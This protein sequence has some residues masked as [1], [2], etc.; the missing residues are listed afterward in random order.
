MGE[1]QALSRLFPE[2]AGAFTTLG[3][4]LEADQDNDDPGVYAF[5]KTIGRTGIFGLRRVRASTYK[6]QIGTISNPVLGQIEDVQTAAVADRRA[7]A[8]IWAYSSTGFPDLDAA[9]DGKHSIIATVLPLRDFPIDAE[10]GLPDTTQLQSQGGELADLDSGDPDLST[11]PFDTLDGAEAVLPQVA[12]GKPG[13]ETFDLGTTKGGLATSLF[14]QD[15][16]KTVFVSQVLKG[17]IL[18]FCDEDGNDL[19]SS[20][21]FLQVGTD[22][23]TGDPVEIVQG[24]TIFVT[25]PGATNIVA[26]DPPTTE[27]LEKLA[28]NL[29]F[30]R[31]GFD[32]GINGRN[33]TLF[34]KTLRSFSDPSL[35]GFKEW[36]GQR[37]PLPG[38][39]VDMDV[40]FRNSNTEPTE[41]PA[42][43]GSFYNDD[44]D[45]IIPYLSITDTEIERL[46]QAQ[47]VFNVIRYTDTAEPGALYPDEIHGTDGVVYF[48]VTGS[49]PPGALITSRD[50]TPVTTQGF[51]YPRSG[52]GDLRPY[53]LL[54]IQTDPSG[55]TIRVGSQG[56]L[57]VGRI[58]PFNGLETRVEPPRFVSPTTEGD[59]IRYIFE[60][61]IQH[62]AVESPQTGI[63]VSRTGTVTTFDASGAS[64]IFAF[65]NGAGG[66]IG[67]L[68][69]IVSPPGVF[70]YPN[71][72]N[73][74]RINLFKPAT[75]TYLQTVEIRVDT[76]GAG[77]IAIGDLAPAGE[78]INAQPTFASKVFAIDTNNPIVTIAAIPGP[79][80]LPEDPLNP[81]KSLPLW[82]TI[83]VD[84][85]SGAQAASVT[86]SVG[87][88]RLT[89][90]ETLDFRSVLD[91][92]APP[93]DSRNVAGSLDIQF[94]SGPT[95]DAVT[96]NAASETN[97]GAVFYFAARSTAWPYV[98]TFNSVGI[99]GNGKGTVRVT[100]F[101]GFGNSPVVTPPGGGAI[102]AAVPSSG[103]D[104][105]G[106]I[107]DGTGVCE[108]ADVVTVPTGGYYDF[109]NRI[110][111]P[112]VAN[113][114]IDNIESGDILII[115]SSDGT[116]VGTTKAGTYLVKHAIKPTV[117]TSYVEQILTVETRPVSRGW[118]NI[119]FPTLVDADVSG[120]GTITVS[121]I[122]GPGTNGSTFASSGRLYIIRDEKDITDTISIAYT[123]IDVNTGEFTVVSGS[124]LDDDGATPV[125]DSVFDSLS[126][127]LKVSGMVYL[128]VN[129]SNALEFD[130]PMPPNNVLGYRGDG[131]F[132]ATDGGTAYGL[133]G[134]TIRNN[135]L[136]GSLVFDYE[137]D[138]NPL[139]V[140]TQL[141]VADQIRVR[142]YSPVVA[143][144]FQTDEDAVFYPNVPKFIDLS[145]VSAASWDT[146][147]N[148][149]AFGVA[150]IFPGDAFDTENSSNEGAR[151]QAG[152]FLEPSFPRSIF[153][154]DGATPHVVDAARSLTSSDV[155]M[156]S[157][158]D[159]GIL[160]T[161]AP[162]GIF[163]T[164]EGVSF[165]VR[166]I[167]RFHQAQETASD[168][169]RGL[170]FAYE[171]RT[172]TVT[173][174][175]SDTVGSGVWPYVLRATGG[176]NLG[177]F[178]D[179]DVNIKPGDVVRLLDSDGNLLDQQSIATVVD[180]TRLSITFPGFTAVSA[181]AI[182]GLRFE[183]Y[184]RQAV[185]PHKQSHEQLL[186]LIT[187]EILLER[188]A[189][190]TTQDGGFVAT[191]NELQ[192][193]DGGSNINF[194][195]TE[196][197]E[198]DIVIVDSAGNVQGPGGLP[199]TG[200]ETGKRPFGDKSVSPRAGVFEAGGPSELDDNR[201]FY[202]VQQVDGDKL[203]VSGE[204]EFTGPDGSP[205]IFPIASSLPGE[206]EYAV[207]P[208]ISDS[209]LTTGTEGQMD[210]R[211]TA[212][213]GQSG[214]PTDSFRGNAYSIAPFSYRVIR[215]S[216]LFSREAI[217][218]IL[219]MRERMLSWAEELDLIIAGGKSGS[220]F[221]FQRDEHIEDLGDPDD[222]ETGLGLLSN[223]FIEG[224]GGL[225]EIS[226]FANTNDALSILDR[227]FWILDL[228]L[229]QQRP[230]FQPGDPTYTTFE[231]NT[232]N[233][234]VEVGEGRPVMVD[235]IDEILNTIDRFRQLRFAWINFRTNREDGTLVSID[236]FIR[237]L[238]KR[239]AEQFRALLLSESLQNLTT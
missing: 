182:P 78:S 157:G 222:P 75:F 47:S 196:I 60:N 171:I 63:V 193:Q 239:E 158:Q 121:D 56:I 225:V 161:P 18:T 200:Q 14:G 111:E 31:N 132:L 224:A 89:F 235:R 11:P 211:P 86:A 98:G 41:I 103:Y 7:R 48:A 134:I 127:G 212:Y 206:T 213:A 51:Y 107:C 26:S 166:R 30:Y 90:T 183:I 114:D 84:T 153:D 155:G 2:S 191:V 62:T 80:E 27:E 137:N 23:T 159:F 50:L 120:A 13:G 79:G 1:P 15:Q 115:D 64:T 106:I 5:R 195:D 19:T 22:P 126:A 220:Y 91:R 204:T 128:A 198:G 29:P 192:D 71:N 61:A 221:V 178:D 146:I 227:R 69:N 113:G 16:L 109:D 162:T 209:A 17:A 124:G 93:I 136:G 12:L 119:E 117:A 187:D 122:S 173:D 102:F 44:G 185:V 230:P 67:G 46:G 150:T 154:L 190:Y 20:D 83:D 145:N 21:D 174:Y 133:R 94:I 82:F 59:R 77:P 216:T 172:G 105:N 108:S 149:T 197:Q 189:D 37:P 232:G 97:G 144:V 88:D 116:S 40:T 130:P 9:S 35:F 55:D 226:P 142:P 81:G 210:L 68:N 99:G 3:P 202:Y 156:R 57:S 238:P 214:S 233:P 188:E 181:G 85:A 118:L 72:D 112:V 201:G 163:A 167:R 143:H 129:Y 8:R 194:D 66:F 96:V 219:M 70:S 100:G 125:S 54:L 164:P 165:Q 175:G 228:R 169:L 49:S 33:G 43:Q 205:V 231:N 180:S 10:T 170:R 101:E 177:P 32:I 131:T 179:P 110:A 186:D 34:D 236:R 237:E 24:D 6:K 217:E 104:E 28:K 141:A 123:A 207:Y 42:L 95:S 53:D 140:V 218:L 229:D 4:G 184:L 148:S 38:S 223:A 147:H 52:V 176:T 215:P 36:F 151:I 199:A 92:L 168:N 208:S 73:I 135:G 25:I 160:P 65:N 74:I 138:A 87:T 39:T 234:L 139:R 58:E 203:V 152:I 76:S 45:L